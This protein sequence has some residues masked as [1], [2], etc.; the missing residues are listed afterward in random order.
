VVGGLRGGR[1][2]CQLSVALEK[3]EP[4]EKKNNSIHSMMMVFV[5]VAYLRFD[6]ANSYRR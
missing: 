3:M 1:L 6:S 5:D 2:A 4:K